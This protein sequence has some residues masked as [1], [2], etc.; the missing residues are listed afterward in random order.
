MT[1]DHILLNFA[2]LLD[3][4]LAQQSL[5]KLPLAADENKETHRP[6]WFEHLALIRCLKQIPLLWAQETPGKRRQNNCKSHSGSRKQPPPIQKEQN[7]QELRETEAMC[8]SLFQM[9]F[10]SRQTE[11]H[12]PNLKQSLINNHLRMNIKFSPMDSHQGKK[13][14]LRG[15]AACHVHMANREQIQQHLWE[16]LVLPC[17]IGASLK[18]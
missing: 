1:L 15:Q 14:L 3:R 9:W 13:L 5:V 6:T 7:T 4:S 8:T 12:A 11:T 18:I 10:Q 17:C 16:F 2:I